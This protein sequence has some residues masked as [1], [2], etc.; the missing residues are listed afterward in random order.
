MDGP[1]RRGFIDDL[2]V[3]FGYFAVGCTVAVAAVARGMPLWSPILLSLTHVSGTSQGAIVE[4]VRVVDGIAS[5]SIDVLFACVALN[6]RYVLLSLAVA[7]RLAPDAT[8]PRRLV[9]A[10]GVT[11]ENVALAVARHASGD[12]PGGLPWRYML[13]VLA[14]SYLGWNLGTA[15]GAFGAHLLP[16]DRLAPLGI[17]LYAMFVAIVVPAAR[18]SWRM[19]AC[20]AIAAALNLALTLVPAL[21]ARISPSVAM[22][23]S[24]TASALLG[25]MLWPKRP[26][27]SGES[28]DG[29]PAVA[30]RRGG[31]AT[32][33][34]GRP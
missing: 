12:F 2:P 3:F 34:E 9:L 16:A 4:G 13:G 26:E 14:S 29:A 5:A 18:D 1:F 31:V 28:G 24:G 8:I 15:A 11:D 10:M 21:A 23:V 27:P 25:A 17:A 33:E 30:R 22:L 19:L 32:S 20:V 6:L 7:Q